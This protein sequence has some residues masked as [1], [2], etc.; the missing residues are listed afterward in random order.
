MVKR[1]AEKP[2]YLPTIK[3][4]D[5][6]MRLDCGTRRWSEKD[7]P[8]W[9]DHSFP[10]PFL[11][12]F[13]ELSGAD[14]YTDYQCMNKVRKHPI[15]VSDYF[16]HVVYPNAVSKI[17]GTLPHRYR[18][19]AKFPFHFNCITCTLFGSV[20][21][22]NACVGFRKRL[23]QDLQTG[24][25][26]VR[27][28][29]ISRLSSLY[30]GSVDDISTLPKF[31]KKIRDRFDL[32]GLMQSCRFSSA[33]HRMLIPC[34]VT[35]VC[36]TPSYLKRSHSMDDCSVITILILGT[37]CL[38]WSEREFTD[39][40]VR[41]S[42][43]TSASRLPLSRLGQPGSI[44]ALVLP[45]GG[46]A[47]RLGKPTLVLPSGGVAARHRKGVTVERFLYQFRLKTKISSH[48]IPLPRK[49]K[50]QNFRWPFVVV[51]A[52]RLVDS[53]FGLLPGCSSLAKVSRYTAVD[54]NDALPRSKP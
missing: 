49:G 9:A 32:E 42:N 54:S 37:R 27:I 23:P 52:A 19:T 34:V 29:R 16:E 15:G 40:K 38:K 22:Q 33:T 11:W 46:M 21:H 53:K 41:G 10:S 13:C 2:Q 6:P 50:S 24:T 36:T 44:P 47:A 1:D 20:P 51:Q 17:S 26:A 7:L 48:S 31:G 25:V 8:T 45:S 14:G 5:L 3:A 12:S 43:P 4:P 39:R 18:W 28:R 30:A 35:C